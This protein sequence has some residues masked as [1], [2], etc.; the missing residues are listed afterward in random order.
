MSQSGEVQAWKML[1]GGA[2]TLGAGYLLGRATA[3]VSV[4]AAASSSSSSAATASKELIPSKEKLLPRRPETSNNSSLNVNTLGSKMTLKD[5]DWNG[6]RVLVR[7][8]YNVPIKDGIV[9][10]SNRID[11]TIPTIRHLM[12]QGTPKC[13][14]LIA[15]LGQPSGKYN[16]ADY[17]LKPAADCLAKLLP[18]YKVRFLPAC[19]GPEVETEINNCEPGTIFL[20]ENLRFH[21]AEIG[22]DKDENKKE[23]KASKEEVAEFRAA[24]SRLGDVFVFEAFGASHRPHS[25][26]VGINIPQRVGGLLMQKE[27]DYFSKVL[28]NP[29]RPFTAVM[30]GAKI[31]DK[32]LII[33]N[34]LEICDDLI[35]GGGMAYTFKKVA[36]GVNIGKSLFD[37]EGSKHVEKILAKAKERG[38]RIHLPVDHVIGDKFDEKARVGVTDDVAGIP[39]GWMGLDVGPKSRAMFSEVMAQSQTILWNGPLGAFEMGPFAAGT[40]SLM[41]DMVLATKRGAT[42]IIGGG[43]TGAASSR[44]FF[45]SESCANQVS[46]VSTGGGSSLVL[47]E[48]KMLPGIE[49][50]SDM[51]KSK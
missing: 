42:T 34:L 23:I 27:L 48:G 24:L 29:S 41:I 51:P 13:L 26:I 50:L 20:L 6:K 47:M 8:D 49:A 15:H 7:V 18:E 12:T 33:E 4:S 14:V 11:T 2:V 35:I 28:G 10:D 40:L 39:D 30:G 1:L 43:D 32:I 25:S 37:E 5:I 44:F 36:Q 17:T 38:V 31:S 9:T 46:H 16:R 45:Q 22:K 21:L 3:P 19:V